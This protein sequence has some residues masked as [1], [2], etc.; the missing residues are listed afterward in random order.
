MKKVYIICLFVFVAVGVFYVSYRISDRRMEEKQQQLEILNETEGDI[1]IVTR[2]A[3]YEEIKI[4][5]ITTI[6]LQ[7][8]DLNNDTFEEK[9]INT[10][11]EFLEMT[12]SDLIEYMKEYLESPDVEDEKRGLM[13]YELVEFSKKSV[14]LRKTYKM[15]EEEEVQYKALLENGYVTIYSSDDDVIYDYTDIALEDLPD[16]I[17]YALKKGIIFNGERELYEFLETYSS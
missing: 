17:K 3:S 16:E 7:V 10:P 8:N 1:E 15:E 4:T 5:N 11:V 9:V 12:R 2:P 14:V 6:K 13:A